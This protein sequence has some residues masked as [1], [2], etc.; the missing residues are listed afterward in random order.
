MLQWHLV[1][2]KKKK[3]KRIFHFLH[4]CSEQFISVTKI[5]KSPHPLLHLTQV[6]GSYYLCYASTDSTEWQWSKSTY[7]YLS[8]NCLERGGGAIFKRKTN[9]LACDYH[10]TLHCLWQ[11]CSSAVLAFISRMCFYT[12]DQKEIQNKSLKLRIGSITAENFLSCFSGY[13]EH[14]QKVGQINYSFASIIPIKYPIICFG[15]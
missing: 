6:C 9:Y 4:V 1:F 13:I 2:F 10:F 15:V 14:E 7:L 5:F 3:K 8:A 11:F 12:H